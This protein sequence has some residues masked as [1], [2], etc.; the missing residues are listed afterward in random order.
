MR[1][2]L[3]GILA[4]GALIHDVPL[5]P[6]RREVLIGATAATLAASAS[7]ALGAGAPSAKGK[8]KLSPRAQ[9]AQDIAQGVLAK[10]K[11]PS[12]S[13]A[14]ASPKAVLWSGSYGHAN[15]EFDIPASTSHLFR[16]GSVSKVITAVLAARLVSRG[17]ID[18]DKAIAIWLP[19]LPAQHRATT[20][21]QLL[22][23]RGGV[24][25]YK[26]ADYDLSGI[27][28]PIY[29]RFYKSNQEVLDLFINDPLIAPQDTRSA[30]PPS[31]LPSPRS[32]WKRRQAGLS[33]R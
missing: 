24:R 14:I 28:G 6:N 29:T 12:L 25:H 32:S 22:T 23:H 27:G 1:R 31:A 15:I 10:F 3:A 13:M 9:A 16:L 2:D 4:I 20:L 26:P 7:P 17:T 8:S 18:L 33:W 5:A 19:N 11:P 30:I 21:R